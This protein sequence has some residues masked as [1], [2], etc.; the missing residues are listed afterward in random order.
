MQKTIVLG[1]PNYDTAIRLSNNPYIGSEDALQK[2]VAM[3]L[4]YKSAF[5]FHPPNGGKRNNIE[6]AKLKGMG[7]LP[8]IPDCMILDARHGFYGLAIE[9][10]VG[11]NKA[12]DNQLLVCH[13]LSEVGWMVVISS[14]LDDVISVL[15]W[16][17][18]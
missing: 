3:Y 4:K 18:D 17:Y 5:W 12:T 15:D 8:G 1:F 13:R 11:H 10:K 9:L 16:Y 14:S 6:A 7:V 2:V